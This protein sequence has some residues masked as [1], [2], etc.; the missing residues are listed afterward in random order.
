MV[1]QP[2]LEQTSN[3]GLS[4]SLEGAIDAWLPVAR[5]QIVPRFPPPLEG[6][7]QADSS[8][9]RLLGLRVGTSVGIVTGCIIVPSLWRLLPDAHPAI[10]WLWC[11]G[12]VPTALVSW[13]ALWARLPVALQEAQSAVSGLMVAGWFTAVLTST[14]APHHSIYLGGMLLL[15][16]LDVVAAGFRFPVAAA[17]GGGLM[18]IFSYGLTRVPGGNHVLNVLLFMIMLN[19][20]GF[21]LFGCWRV[22]SETR[23]SYARMLRER[24]QQKALSARNAELDMLALRDP[25]TGLANRRAYQSWQS[26][27]WQAAEAACM[28]VGLV[29]V[30]IDHFK[31]FNDFYGH[32][33]G[34]ACLQAVARCMDD[35]MRGTTDLVARLGGEEFAILLPGASLA[36]AG[37]VPSG[38]ALWLRR[39]NCPMAVAARGLW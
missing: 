21:A 38:C 13:L 12:G 34:D 11:L 4:P 35:H 22:E 39:W 5:Q 24:L 20:T 27:A 10:I 1:S 36:V 30:D 29:M 26:G 37:D 31:K 6:H 16:M 2:S 14:S 23:H 8:A 25:L 32:P 19:L 7:Y 3:A 15:L 18:L 28:S 9:S 33:A 17:Y